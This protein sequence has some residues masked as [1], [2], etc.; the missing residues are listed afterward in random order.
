MLLL[1]ELREGI[2]VVVDSTDSHVVGV[3]VL[4]SNRYQPVAAPEATVTRVRNDYTSGQNPTTAAYAHTQ[5]CQA[6]YL[7]RTCCPRHQR[8]HSRRELGSLPRTDRQGHLLRVQYLPSLNE[9][10]V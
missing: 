2:E 8:F 5:S 7:E 10:S 1:M 4:W 3:L 9:H 6:P